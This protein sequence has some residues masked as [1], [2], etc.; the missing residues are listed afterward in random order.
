MIDWQDLRFLLALA[1]HG[2]L[3]EAAAQLDVN[4]TTVARRIETLERALQVK[5]VERIGRDVVLTASGR[6]VLAVAETIHGEVQSLER[7]VAGRDQHLAGQ[8]R[9][10]ATPRIATLISQDL[11][12]F[13]ELHPDVLL[14]VSATN[15]AED[16]ELMEADIAIRLTSNPPEGLVGHELARPTSALYA[17]EA[18]AARLPGLSTI[19]YIGSAIGA[20]AANWIRADFAAEPHL[21]LQSNSMDLIRELVAAGRGVASIPCYVGEGVSGL[22]RVNA[23]RRDGMPE[24]WLLYHPRLRR[25]QRVQVFVRFLVQVFERLRPV[26]EGR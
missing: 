13:V 2:S 16:L 24:L 8:I 5:L 21:V 18:L 23:P 7:R 9:I 20:D 14:D 1:H 4:R 12:R 15:A 25:I 17:S 26:I 22:R 6:E 10:T 3:G 19:D 11:A